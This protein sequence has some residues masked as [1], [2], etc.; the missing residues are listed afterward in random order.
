MIT[1]SSALVRAHTRILQ[2]GLFSFPECR[3]VL[4]GALWPDPGGQHEAVHPDRVHLADEQRA[5]TE[6][7]GGPERD[8]PHH[9]SSGSRAGA[10]AQGVQRL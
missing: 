7:N 4:Q 1:V 3:G 10:A 5:L 6:G 2:C 9:G 8:L